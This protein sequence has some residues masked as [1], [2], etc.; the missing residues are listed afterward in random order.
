MAVSNRCCRIRLSMPRKLDQSRVSIVQTSEA[1]A[2]LF[3]MNSHLG[4]VS[5]MISAFGKEFRSPLTAGNVCTMSPS[6]PSRSTRN[7]G[8]VMQSLAD[9]L[10]QFASRMIFLISDDGH[11]NSQLLG[12]RTLR[13][14]FRRVIR[15]L[16]VYVGPHVIEQRFHVWFGKNDDV[17][18]VAQGGH[19]QRARAF[20][21]HRTSWALQSFYAR[22]AVHC[23][24]QHIAFA[25]SAT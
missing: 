25:A 20:V 22:I 18:D 21:Q 6:E 2:L 17:I 9:G 23:D 12:G 14:G 13:H 4:C 5:Q 7:R 24:N 16:C 11:A 1:S 10:Q 8:S 19:Q 3:T 15:S